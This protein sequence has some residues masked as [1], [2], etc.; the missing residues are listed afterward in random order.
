MAESGNKGSASCLRLGDPADVC[1]SVGEDPAL[2]IPE[3]I[4]G[5]PGAAMCLKAADPSVCSK[6]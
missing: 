3:E 5:M 4:I 1:N 6:E 2:K